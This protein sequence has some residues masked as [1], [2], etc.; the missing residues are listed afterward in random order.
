M[1]RS[2]SESRTSSSS[3]VPFPESPFPESAVPFPEPRPGSPFRGQA[4]VSSAT[5]PA[6]VLPSAAGSP[7]LGPSSPGPSGL[8]ASGPGLDRP[9]G[10]APA[11][12]PAAAPA[13]TDSTGPLWTAAFALG[14][15]AI[16]A[17]VVAAVL[18]A[19]RSRPGAAVAAAA[20]LVLM[21]T[22]IVLRQRY[23]ATVAEWEQDAEQLHRRAA[24]LERS[25]YERQAQYNGTL[26]GL[27][28]AVDHLVKVQLPAALNGSDVSQPLP[29]SATGNPEA[30]VLCRRVATAVAEGAAE[31]TEQLDDQIESSR[32]AVVT[33]AR[34]VQA[35]AHRT[36]E[37]ATRMAGRHPNDSDVLESSMRVDHAAAQQA[38]HAQS[39]AVLCGE[40]PGQQWPQPLP[41][42][43]VVRAASSRIVAYR[44]VSVSGEPDTAATASVVEPLIH[45]IA[46]LLANATQSSPPTTQVLVT[47]R[48][49]QRG[50][51]IEMDDGGVG[52]EEHQLEQAR[53]IVSGQ[54]LLRLG[55]LGEIPQTGM[56]V[57]GQ[58]VH[59]H[60]FRVD[61]MPSPYGGV[62]A[63]VLVPADMVENLEHA[64]PAP[65]RA[66][67]PQAAPAIPAVRPP[68][69]PLTGPASP[70]PAAPLAAPA[71]PSPADPS[72]A[73]VGPNPTDPFAG[74]GPDLGS[75]PQRRS[76]RGEVETLAPGQPP[77]ER[78]LLTQT[79][80]QAG[81]WMAAY[82]GGAAGEGTAREGSAGAGSPGTGRSDDPAGS[83][84]PPGHAHSPGNE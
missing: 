11:R 23:S 53:E 38:R 32:L 22:L 47:V 28:E 61:L 77:A 4:T 2:P 44:R 64:A 56:A 82:F 27:S 52:M 76:R 26:K 21:V 84:D 7:S 25:G 48:T 40:W 1:A 16:L 8:G 5:G 12:R 41:L 18:N 65:A 75:L 79:P 39:V 42:L 80:E 57:I 58:Y 51:V 24:E 81:A 36:Q 60:G 46:E 3:P 31:L 71:G 45:L 29:D 6:G 55:D 54:R 83:T 59:R 78:A 37:E 19:G 66:A 70:K 67:E 20:A 73:L 15:C 72:A 74:P 35:S 69:D 33:L 17:S 34:R 63:V 30:A 62:R 9:P 43:D 68:A 13:G 14:A 10:F 49:V 50:A